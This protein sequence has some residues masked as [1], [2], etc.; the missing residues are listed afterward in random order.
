MEYD[1]SLAKQAYEL[2]TRWDKARETADVS[3]LEFKETDLDDFNSN[4]ISKFFKC[5]VERLI[6]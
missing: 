6:N 1:L 3:H 5:P 2:A 4:Q